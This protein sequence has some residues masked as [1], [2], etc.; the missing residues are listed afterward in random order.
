MLK[1][2]FERRD[3]SSVL[4]RIRRDLVPL[5]C[6]EYKGFVVCHSACLFTFAGAFIV[7]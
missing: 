4:L 5:G 2:Y 1:V 7:N 3:L 6:E